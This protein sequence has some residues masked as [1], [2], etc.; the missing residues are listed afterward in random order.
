M[1]FVN[2]NR[3]LF[4]KYGVTLHIVSDQRWIALPEWVKIHV[5]PRQLKVYSPA[6]V[7]NY[8]IRQAGIGIVCK[9]DIDC[10][11]SEEALK[12]I[13]KVNPGNGIYFYYLM[14]KT[15]ETRH[16]NQRWGSTCGTMALH[17]DDWNKICGYDERQEGYGIEDGDGVARAR[18]VLQIARSVANVYHISH[19]GSELWT[20]T[21]VCLR[22]DLW[23][24]KEG[25]CPDR[26]SAN[27][28]I[29]DK[30]PKWCNPDWGKGIDLEPSSK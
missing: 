10:V 1:D 11:L 24:R 27:R 29:R 22:R 20:Q 2:W 19:T 13:S 28:E 30:A 16:I 18:A 3:A 8:G 15:Y 7:S 6:K 17:F 12:D 25:F 26:H 21:N 23:N 4:E 5:Y 9:T 14:A